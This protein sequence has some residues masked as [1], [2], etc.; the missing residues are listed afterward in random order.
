MS[1]ENNSLVI[2]KNNMTITYDIRIEAVYCLLILCGYKIISPYSKKY[3]L[4]IFQEF[5]DIL[6]S[7]Y[8]KHYSKICFDK[9]RYV[10]PCLFALSTEYDN[11]MIYQRRTMKE[12]YIKQL[13]GND[14]VEKCIESINRFINESNY[15]N[16]FHENQNEY[17]RY[18]QKHKNLL[19]SVMNDVQNWYGKDDMTYT[20]YLSQLVH[21]GGFG[22][23][24]DSPAC[25]LGSIL[26]PDYSINESLSIN[27][28]FHEFSHYFIDKFI[29]SNWQDIHRKVSHLSSNISSDDYVNVLCQQEL[30]SESIIRAIA[31]YYCYKQSQSINM[32]DFID[33]PYTYTLYEIMKKKS[34]IYINS[35]VLDMLLSEVINLMNKEKLK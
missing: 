16:F 32:R 12:D 22:V 30:F 10:I 4:K 34:I 6:E 20:A 23:G 5:Y 15:L 33:Y 21:P 19:F 35:E 24:I 26:N 31:N 28:C 3:Q 7:D 1:S 14:E 29:S 13:G 17:L 11:G 18:L 25:V 8:V 27:V 9:F 2:N